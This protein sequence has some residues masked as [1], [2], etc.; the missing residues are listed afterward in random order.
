MFTRDSALEYSSTIIHK[1]VGECARTGLSRKE[2]CSSLNLSNEALAMWITGSR[3]CQQFWVI[4]NAELL[5]EK[6]E[7]TEDSYY[8]KHKANI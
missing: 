1:L 3:T 4:R 2:L 6:L 8:I 5:L 7:L